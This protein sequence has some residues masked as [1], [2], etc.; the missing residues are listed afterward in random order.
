MSEGFAEDKSMAAVEKVLAPEF[1]LITFLPSC[2]GFSYL[3][4]FLRR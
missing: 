3:I 2:E 1:E 4:D